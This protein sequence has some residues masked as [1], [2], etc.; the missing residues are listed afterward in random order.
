MA[1]SEMTST[2][3][4]SAVGIATAADADRVFATLT[5]AFSADPLV[6]WVYPDP[7]QYWTAWPEML[8]LYGAAA[9]AHGTVAVADGFAGV[10]LWLPPGVHPDE[11]ALGELVQRS[12]S[13]RDQADVFHV[14]AQMEAAHPR[15]PHWYL[16]FI[17]VAPLHQGKGAGS[18]LLRH[19]LAWCDRDGRPAYLDATSPGSRRLY[20]RHGFEVVTTVQVGSS[21]PVWPMLRTPR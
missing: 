8:R 3:M 6:R 18:A 12:V 1:V 5:H 7:R 17:G 9:F 11:A 2:E 21:P 20:E 14:L 4:T 19:S 13:E 16:P 10:A 15:E